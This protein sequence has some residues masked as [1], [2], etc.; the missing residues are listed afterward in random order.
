MDNAAT[1]QK[2]KKVINALVEYY[3]QYNAN[4]HRGTYVLS[5]E[6]T[7]EYESVRSKFQSFLNDQ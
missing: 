1:T 3:E 5:A 4:V 7:Q 2:P 6:T